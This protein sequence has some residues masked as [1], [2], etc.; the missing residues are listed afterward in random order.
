M[1][2]KEQIKKIALDY[3]EGWYEANQKR[4]ENALHPKLVKRRFVTTEEI[5]QVDTP[6]MLKI[7]SEGRGKLPE[8]AKGRK[9]ITI[10]DIQ[11]KIASVKVHSEKFIDYLLLVKENNEWKIVDAIWDYI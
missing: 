1:L 2:E 6:T 9:D 8:P 7:T 11:D 10:L 5:W 3:I 4:M